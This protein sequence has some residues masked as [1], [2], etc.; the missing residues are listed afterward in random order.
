MGSNSGAVTGTRSTFLTGGANAGKMHIGRIVKVVEHAWASNTTFPVMALDEFG[1]VFVTGEW[2]AWN[3]AG[4]Y[5][6]DNSIDF[7]GTNDFTTRFVKCYTQPEPFIDI[8][9]YNKA[10]ESEVAYMGVGESGQVYVGGYG[11]Y[12]NLGNKTSYSMDG[13]TKLLSV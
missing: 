8:T 3:P 6:N 7:H 2:A 12:S 9:F 4:Y 11:G 1:Q 13:W 10:A 5:N